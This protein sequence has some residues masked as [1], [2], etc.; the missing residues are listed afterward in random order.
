MKEIRK[1]SLSSLSDI[2]I[3]SNIIG[4]KA[5]PQIRSLLN[6]KSLPEIAQMNDADLIRD[7]QLMPA[8]ARKIVSSFELS[9]RRLLSEAVKK[10]KIT[11]STDIF[12]IFKPIL[13]DLTHEEFHV[14]YLNRAL[15]ILSIEKISIG[16]ISGT[17]T[18]IRIILKRAL[19]LLASGMVVCHNHPSGNNTP[20]ESDTKIT[21][22]IGES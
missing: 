12:D 22:K 21:H 16:G 8:E 10:E 7:Y 4:E 13:T 17:V 9:R 19:E 6:K 1:R 5:V 20:S 15:A 2:E 18:D 11:N 3:I 14:M